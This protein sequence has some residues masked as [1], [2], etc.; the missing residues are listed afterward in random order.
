MRGEKESGKSFGNSGFLLFARAGHCTLLSHRGKMQTAMLFFED[1]NFQSDILC[2]AIRP[3]EE[4]VLAWKDA[5]TSSKRF[6]GYFVF[7]N[8]NFS[9]IAVCRG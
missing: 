3:F 6:A 1:R 7:H 9:R 5:N 8:E 4:L 2:L